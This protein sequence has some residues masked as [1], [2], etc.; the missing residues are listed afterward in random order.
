MSNFSQGIDKSELL[1]ITRPFNRHATCLSLVSPKPCCVIDVLPQQIASQGTRGQPFLFW[2]IK[3]AETAPLR[4]DFNVK[5]LP[6]TKKTTFKQDRM[7]AFPINSC[8]RNIMAD[9]IKSC[10]ICH[11]IIAVA[12]LIRKALGNVSVV[13]SSIALSHTSVLLHLWNCICLL[14]QHRFLPLIVSLGK[15]FLMCEGREQTWGGWAHF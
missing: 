4:S 5:L 10:T 11:I 2:K 8:T 12:A 13:A 7:N 1:F 9:Y 6:P 3:P 14:R 15:G